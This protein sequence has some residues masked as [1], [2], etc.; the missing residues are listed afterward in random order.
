MLSHAVMSVVQVFHLYDVEFGLC[1][2]V[3]D[4]VSHPSRCHLTVWGSM[5][6]FEQW[7]E[8][9][10]GLIPSWHVV[11]ECAKDRILRVDNLGKHVPPRVWYGVACLLNRNT[12]G[13]VSC[14][15]EWEMAWW[16]AQAHMMKEE[17]VG[18]ILTLQVGPMWVIIAKHDI[19]L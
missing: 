10:R 6:W 14:S 19:L 13:C 18:E 16:F 12:I 5:L 17:P 8:W 1:L 2:S 3:R 4:V 7:L 9:W 15:E 11:L